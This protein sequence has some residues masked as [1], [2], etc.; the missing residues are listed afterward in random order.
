[1][2]R[3]QCANVVLMI[4]PVNFFYN[5]ETALSNVFQKKPEDSINEIKNM[6]LTEFDNAVELLRNEGLLV[7][8]INPDKMLNIPDQVFPNNWFQVTHDGKLILFPMQSENRRKERLQY[9]IDHL[10]KKYLISDVID[11]TFH[12]KNHL[13]LEGTGSVVLDHN[14]MT[15]YAVKSARTS[16]KVF[17]EY[18]KIIDYKPVFFRANEFK[19]SSI[20]HTNVLMSLGPGFAIICSEIINKSDRKRVLESFLN[21]HLELVDVRTEQMEMFCGNVLTVKSRNGDYLLIMSDKAFNA[22]NQNQ[23]DVLSKYAKLI[24]VNVDHIENIGGGGIRC[25][26]A[27]IYS[28]SI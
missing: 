8:V 9:I 28:L 21:D 7:D 22:F 26:M 4:K 6:V 17:N 16:E 3:T 2:K 15:A 14:S 10:K 27:E 20:Y 1:M 25:M 23:K 19:G 24:K 18:C 13:F 12:E 11:L 5:S